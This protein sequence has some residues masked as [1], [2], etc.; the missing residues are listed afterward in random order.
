MFYMSSV[1]EFRG[2]TALVCLTLAPAVVSLIVRS[3]HARARQI[4]A[5]ARCK[6]EKPLILHCKRR[7]C[8]KRPHVE[9]DLV[10]IAG[11]SPPVGQNIFVHHGARSQ[12][13]QRQRLRGESKTEDQL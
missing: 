2:N 7:Q 4:C 1:I 10:A 8:A 5:G 6:V 9:V 12:L 13:G 3:N 11:K